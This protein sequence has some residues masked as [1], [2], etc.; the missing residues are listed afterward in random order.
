LPKSAT[1][2]SLSNT[3]AAIPNNSPGRVL[4]KL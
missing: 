2:R 4:K 1:N 3:V